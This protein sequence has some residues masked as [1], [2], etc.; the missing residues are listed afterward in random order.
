[1]WQTWCFLRCSA[2]ARI[3]KPGSRGWSHK[4]QGFEGWI[5]VVSRGLKR[6]FVD[7][8]GYVSVGTDCQKRILLSDFPGASRE[9][10]FFGRNT[11]L[12]SGFLEILRITIS[13]SWIFL[14]TARHTSHSSYV[15]SPSKATNLFPSCLQ[16][17]WRHLQTPLTC[18]ANQMLK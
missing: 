9:D 6:F 15:Q 12:K 14:T 13:N 1:M 3:S 2:E 17:Q 10:F 16:A 11:S 7:S 4:S 5:K 18:V 8:S